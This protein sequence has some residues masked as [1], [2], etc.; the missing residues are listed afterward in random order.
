MRLT[1]KQI[2]DIL[3]DIREE[4]TDQLRRLLLIDRMHQHYGSNPD[5]LE[6]LAEQSW[7]IVF[8]HDPLH[9]NPDYLSFSN[10]R[11]RIEALKERKH[12]GR[13]LVRL[14]G[15]RLGMYRWIEV[16]SEDLKNAQSEE[17]RYELLRLKTMYEFQRERITELSVLEF[18][19]EYYFETSQYE[20]TMRL[21]YK[22]VAF[23]L[24]NEG[25]PDEF[26]LNPSISTQ[27]IKSSVD[28]YKLTYYYSN[29]FNL[30]WKPKDGMRL[31]YTYKE[32]RKGDIRPDPWL[33]WEEEWFA[34]LRPLMSEK[35][36]RE[37]DRRL[38]YFSKCY[39]EYYNQPKKS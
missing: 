18:L 34:I 4:E 16:T 1:K 27:Y 24:I 31:Y 29:R 14:L 38:A 20:E 35:G 2:D 6:R 21:E 30:G 19:M 13:H 28:W 7:N 3:R 8:G 12:S 9:W 11:E 22:E 5:L 26:I 23:I 36:K 15:R 39:K 33:F 17:G 25:A 37:L 10:V 32:I